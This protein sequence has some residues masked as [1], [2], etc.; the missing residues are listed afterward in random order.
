MEAHWL[1]THPDGISDEMHKKGA[2]LV[3]GDLYDA[4]DRLK[5]HLALLCD[6]READDIQIS[7]ENAKESAFN[8][9]T[10]S[11]FTIAGEGEQE[12]ITIT[13]SK[14]FGG[15][16][17]NLNTPFQKWEDEYYPYRFA[18]ELSADIDL[19]LY[20]ITQ[21]L[22]EGKHEVRQLEMEFEV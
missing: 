15:K 4:L 2:H 18:G 20:E 10:V 11:G 5:P 22:F 13:G 14:R 8:N 17:I 12:G 19:C 3:H 16:V 6:L 9:I 21:Y 1:E 7:L